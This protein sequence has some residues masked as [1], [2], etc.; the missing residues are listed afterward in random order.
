M[1]VLLVRHGQSENNVIQERLSPM[2]ARGEISSQ[3]MWAMWM[4][5]RFDDPALTAKGKAEAVKLGNFYSRWIKKE[6]CGAKLFASGMLRAAQTAHPLSVA[7]SQPVKLRPDIFEVGGIYGS[8]DGSRSPMTT[9]G[10]TNTASE[11]QSLF[12]TYIVCDL[13]Q[14]GMWY[15]EGYESRPQAIERAAKVATW[16]KSPALHSEVGSDVA[17]MVMHADFLNL[18]VKSLLG[19]NQN[20]LF[21]NT[22]TALLDIAITGKINVH[23][24]VRV[25][26]LTSSL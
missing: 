9:P 24:M 6:G 10:K 21:S 13:P 26:H 1:R 17:I 12:P 2:L 4:K 14:T 15:T 7:L 22:S 25:D 20:V 19:T 3:E 16:L 8:D 23:W 11:L 5:E 18:L